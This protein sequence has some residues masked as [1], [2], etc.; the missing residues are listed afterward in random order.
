M[1]T[2]LSRRALLTLAVCGAATA[3]A[4]SLDYPA[5]PVKIIVP[6]AAGGG[7]DA[8][9]RL[10]AD[11]LSASL[12]QPFVV[13]NRAGG[14]GTIG[15]EFAAR[16]AADGYTLLFTGNNHTLNASL[17]KLRFDAKKDFL[18][19]SHA[20]NTYQI[21]L[22][23]P[24]VGVS[25]IPELVRAA[26]ARPGQLAYGSAGAGTPSH[27]A[28]VVFA[29]MAGITLNHIPYKGAGPATSDLLGGQIQL[30][31]SSLPSAL[32]H[33]EAGKVKALGISSATRTPLA[34]QLPTIAEGGLAGYQQ[35]TWFG[36]LAPAGTPEAIRLKLSNEIAGILKQP[37][38]LKV[39]QHNGMEAVGSTPAAFGE[40]L[41]KEFAAW[42]EFVK[43]TPIQV[44]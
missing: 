18:P 38:V 42:P 20:V 32:P 23:H 5:R 1:T 39:L 33:V 6:L 36:L 41:D 3:H 24:S 9:A 16:S 29:K 44:D 25:T 34:P 28:G 31:F 12:K 35:V 14:S 19:I 8:I 13:E 7:V 10:M 27:V 17:F 15:A 40:L 11:R 26:K 43:D 30:L 37:E 22:A 4:Q 21:L 2:S